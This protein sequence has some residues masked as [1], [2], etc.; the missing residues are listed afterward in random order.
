MSET[1]AQSF[2]SLDIILSSIGD[3]VIAADSSSRVTYLNSVA[4]QLTGWT[5]SEAQGQPLETIFR[6]VNEETHATAEN[7]AL[8]A[9]REGVIFGLANHTLLITRD[10]K[11]IPIDDSGAPIKN[12]EGA[13]VGAVLVFREITERRKAERVQGLLV[14]IVESAEDA[15]VSKNLEGIIEAWNAGAERLFEYSPEEAIGKS[16]R[17]IIPPEC[18]NEEDLILQ[19][20]RRG[21]RIDHFETV[22][23]AKS[24]RM[25]DIDLSVSPV[26]NQRSEI[27]GASK[28]ARDI[29]NRKHLEKER[30]ELLIQAEEARERA[31]AAIIA[32]D[33]FI[34]QVSHEMRTPVNSILG[35]TKVLR[36]VDYE[37]SHTIRA[38][39]TIHRSANVQLQLIED[40]IDLSKIVQGKMHVD[41][42][43][44]QIQD[45]IEQALEAIT[46][47]AEA[48][49]I[50]IENRVSVKDGLIN[51][52]P[53]RLLQV[54]WNLLSNAV[55][56]TPRGG[57][58]ELSVE[59]LN[60]HLEV[61]V[62]DSGIGIDTEFLPYIFDRFTQA[63]NDGSRQTGL[64]LGLA[65]V[66]YFVELHGGNVTAKSDG[67]GKGAT[68]TIVLPDKNIA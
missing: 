5:L 34:A 64:G 36:D 59:R 45:V 11:E 49:S 16:I 54:L 61:S 22:R 21:E 41:M 35:W 68:F 1:S 31:E 51:G 7:P 56:F 48:K 50:A 28:I 40:L 67:D 8:R 38:V 30:A 24:G 13:L 63:R 17:I 19:K 39:D 10:G 27:I 26:R 9:L 44:L 23:V 66:R 47:A 3:G 55:K 18:H 37:R 33:E 62:S 6:I 52:D 58:I 25:V 42:R 60:H 20:L 12:E 65:I 15:I 32:K 57:Q 14:A 46:P 4:E 2:K 43:P 53:E 29:S